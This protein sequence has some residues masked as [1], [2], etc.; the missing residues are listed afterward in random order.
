MQIDLPYYYEFFVDNG[1]VNF[2]NK[3]LDFYKTQSSFWMPPNSSSTIN[4]IQTYNMLDFGED[5]VRCKLQ[6]IKNKIEK[7][8]KT[9]FNYNWS[10][11]IEYQNG[12]NQSIHTHDHNEDFSIILYLNNCND[13]ETVF[14]LNP[15]RQ[16]KHSCF[17]QKGKA[18]MFSATIP[19]QANYT[20]SNKKL[21]V[22]GLKIK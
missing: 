3:K 17:P 9:K 22:L 20:F 10:H 6:I 12:G 16:I 1:I 15:R 11:L 4:G 14:H 18:V 21:L 13:G 2:F 19:H 5:D 7:K 8:C